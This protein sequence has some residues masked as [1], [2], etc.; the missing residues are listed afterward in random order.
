MKSDKTHY[1]KLSNNH[2][3]QRHILAFFIAITLIMPAVTIVVEAADVI[4][5]DDP[6]LGDYDSIQTAINAASPGD[7]IWVK[8]GSY[9]EQLT[10]NVNNLRIIAANGDQPNIYVS[11]YDPG[12][13]ITAHNVT[14]DGFKIYGNGG[15]TVQ[16][17]STAHDCTVENNK[18]T[19]V[20]SELG[21]I[22]CAADTGV[23]GLIFQSNIVSDYNI[24]VNLS[25]GVIA[26]IDDTN[27]F[28]NV[29]H[30]IYN[31]IHQVGVTGTAFYTY[32]GSI[33]DVVDIVSP[34]DE[35]QALA[36]LFTE[37]VIID[38][39]LKLA[40]YQ[41][42]IDPISGRTGGESLIDGGTSH[43][44]RI[45]TGVENVTINGFSLTVT[46][47]DPLSNVAGILIGKNAKNI[48][49]VNNILSN[50]TD[51]GGADSINDE[52]Y[53]IMV[54]GRDIGNGQENIQISNNLIENVEEYGIAINDNTSSVTISNNKITQLI[55][56]D[57][58]TDPIWA[59]TWPSIICSAIHLGG[60]V[61]PI[62]DIRIT[63]NDL[64]TN[65]TGDG[66]A[67]AAGGGISF[68]GVQEWDPPNRVWA[69]FD[70]ILIQDNQI[71]NNTMG[72]VGLA[73]FSNNSIETHEN[74]LSNNVG[75]GV[76][77]LISNLS[78]NA[79]E[80]WW[81]DI[82]GPYNATDNPDGTG[83]EVV[84][85]VTYWPW[86]EF[87]GGSSAP[88]VQYT[89]NGP[90][91]YGGTIISPSTEI[92][93]E[94]EDDEGPIYSLTYRTWN[95]VD[96][97]SSWSNYT[98][99]F[100]LS[101]E[102]KHY[103]QYNATDQAGTKTME[104]R[105]HRVDGQPPTISVIYPNGGEVISGTLPIEWS[106][107]D[108]IVDQYQQDYNDSMPL[109]EDYPG[110]LQSFI[111][112]EDNMRSVQLLIEGDNANISVKLFSQ[113]SPVPQSIGQST[114]HLEMIGSP[115]TP[116]WI[117]FA[118]DAD[119]DLVVGETYYIGVTQNILGDTGFKWYYLNH[120]SSVDPYINGQSWVKQTD[121]LVSEP[122]WD[123]GFKTMYWD[124]DLQITVQYSMTGVS[125]WST[126]AESEY[127]DGLYGWDTS[128]LPDGPNY[129]IRIMADDAISNIGADVS[130]L[131]FTINNAGPS[132]FDVTIMDTTV[133][134]IEYIKNGDS[135]EI[136]ATITGDPIE[137]YADL[138]GLGG[139]TTV[140]PTTFTG[141]I[142]KWVISSVSCNPTDGP[143]EITV[144]ATDATEDDF[145]NTGTIIA[146]NT[147][148]EINII[149]PLPGL[150][151][152]DG[153][154]L[155]PFSYPFI[156]GQITV[157]AD[158]IDDL[159]GI[160]RVEFYLD[161]YLEFSSTQSPYEWVWDRASSG[162][163]TITIKAYDNV[164]HSVVD[165]IE[166]L[167]II[168]LDILGHS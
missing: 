157:R 14:L 106:A 136:T 17:A 40:G 33:Q 44:I 132:V 66:S 5:D 13:Q 1:L 63:N 122:F 141:D 95:T 42:N 165:E 29:S 124:T 8:D 74:N 89:L 121:T 131:K 3:L 76:Y 123:W 149:R 69:G 20:S 57:H 91:E 11:S 35:L 80:N 52:T 152:L 144:F 27:G 65:V 75:Y 58:S 83:S 140:A 61:G 130:D 150:Y 155:L 114:Q 133:G 113:I 2:S 92:E 163:Y 96:G 117:D 139:G 120:S 127:N 68:A 60:Q 19:V 71:T 119:I 90:N 78:F 86:Y 147:E 46:S 51:G 18:F 146:D 159:S 41:Y 79:T 43:A 134:T 23:N 55:G 82:S 151:Y 22:A 126:I 48:E 37:N 62:K 87:E 116:V 154:R 108:K 81:G 145:S 31:A 153:M 64:I 168:N 50:I 135:A 45:A 98:E 24:G 161:D 143:I 148:P 30:Q 26:L 39:E 164:G 109:T 110:H 12:I 137:I 103:V 107:Q 67:S 25:S 97:W 54:Y 9:N 53:G 100:T 15:I 142:A 162:F 77:N 115:G 16:I 102:G 160:E 94:A 28:N 118:F 49:I 32:Y 112:T 105:E 7:V 47:K 129:R 38:K 36:G 10:I 88:L 111:A 104:I 99:P 4:V 166:D 93:I 167:F 125:P 56:S 84:G 34:G 73:G 59:P 128:I 6:G 85:N 156:I 70:N 101:G 138:S 72:L 21:D 158:A